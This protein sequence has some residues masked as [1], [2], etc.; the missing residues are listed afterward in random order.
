MQY[1]SLQKLW[2][3]IRYTQSSHELQ[4]WA[5]E[6]KEIEQDIGSEMYHRI[7]NTDM[8]S[9]KKAEA[10]HLDLQS[11]L[12]EK[13]L[14]ACCCNE[15]SE[16]TVNKVY[17]RHYEYAYYGDES[18][19]EADGI[20]VTHMDVL[21]KGKADTLYRCG[22]VGCRR[23]W[24]GFGYYTD[25]TMGDHEQEGYYTWLQ[26]LPESTAVDILNNDNWPDTLVIEREKDDVCT[27]LDKKE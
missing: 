20:Y 21:K 10:L 23:Y 3:Y 8:T 16:D 19:A 11:L 17:N 27:D 15:L 26:Y 25:N 9:W 12:I 6:T 7:I 2:T 18:S 4:K 1:E 13:G 22:N 14:I 24:L 5:Q